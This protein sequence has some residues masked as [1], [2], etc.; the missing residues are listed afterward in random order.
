[1]A[2]TS[3]TSY[4]L[5]RSIIQYL[6]F[7]DSITGFYLYP[8]LVAMA[9]AWWSEFRESDHVAEVVLQALEANLKYDIFHDK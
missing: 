8:S 9:E 7:I 4:T 5:Y 2:K 6:L 1:M 3:R